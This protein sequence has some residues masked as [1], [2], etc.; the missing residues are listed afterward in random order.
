VDKVNKQILETV[1]D[2]GS[3]SFARPKPS[4]RIAYGRA[5]GADSLLAFSRYI[6][7]DFQSAQ[8][9]KLI[10][11]HLSRVEKGEIK[12]LIIN[13]PPRHGKSN[14]CSKI[15]PTWF[16]GRHPKDEIIVTSFAADKAIE[17]T[18][19]QR[20]TVESELYRDIFPNI[21]TC[22]DSRASRR[23][24][25]TAGGVVIGAGVDGPITGRGGKL[26]V[27]DDPIK[28]YQEAMSE[29]IQ[30]NVWEWYC[31][32]FLTRIYEDT[33]QILIMTRWSS[34]DL[35]GKLIAK[36]GLAENGGK[37]HLLK[38]PAIDADGKALWPER[39]SAEFLQSQRET[40]GEKIFMALYQ[41]EPI[42]ITERLF[43]DPKYEEAPETLRNIGYLDPAFGG[44]DSCAFCCGN[45]ASAEKDSPI[46]VTGGYMWRSTIDQTYDRVE[47]LCKKHRIE[48]LWVESNQAQRLIIYEL[49]KRGINARENNN[50]VNKHLR[51]QNFVKMPWRRLR[52]SHGIDPAFMK[53]VLCYHEGIEHDD[54]PDALAGLISKI[55]SA[56]NDLSQRYNLSSLLFGRR[57]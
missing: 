12:N 9:I 8:H 24:E 38:L 56:C 33:A 45:A 17:F 57:I 47:A 29:K 20:N 22:D 42:D 1:I 7:P 25:I 44:A 51:I 18:R 40:M 31:S 4:D 43:D 53:G 30:D 15:F 10:A 13:M 39:F 50:T 27:I 54:A 3:R 6:M 16:L 48:T 37:W 19:W 34:D 49:K 41:Q 28:N 26:A 21:Q 5:H 46:Y 23:W 35:S 32:T 36:D 14:L 11:E 55:R 52:F 2:S